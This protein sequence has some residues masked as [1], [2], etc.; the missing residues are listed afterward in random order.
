[1]RS[2]CSVIIDVLVPSFKNGYKQGEV[3]IWRKGK[4]SQSVPKQTW[5]KRW[6]GLNK[7]ENERRVKLQFVAVLLLSAV[8]IDSASELGFLEE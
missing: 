8:S 5:P 7:G 1:M 3:I 2:C 4:S 6:E